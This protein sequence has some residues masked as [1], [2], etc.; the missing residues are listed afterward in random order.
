[1]TFPN[2]GQR[3]EGNP[4]RQVERPAAPAWH[5]GF[6]GTYQG[7][8][9]GTGYFS[10][11]ATG[12]GETDSIGIPWSGGEHSRGQRFAMMPG[13][14]YTPPGQMP[15]GWSAH[16]YEADRHGHLPGGK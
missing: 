8:V 1:M 10:A 9:G 11:E 15:G 12:G 6:V 3:D 4:N 14:N 16:A 5:G 7:N 13:K 2:G